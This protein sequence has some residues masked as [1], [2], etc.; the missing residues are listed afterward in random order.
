MSNEQFTDNK[1]RAG[2][3]HTNKYRATEGPTHGYLL[4]TDHHIST[5]QGRVILIRTEQ[6]GQTIE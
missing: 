3:H 1:E 6:G 5:E 2:E 4:G